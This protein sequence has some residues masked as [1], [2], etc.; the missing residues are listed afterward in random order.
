MFIFWL[1]T[2]FPLFSLTVTTCQSFNIA[3]M[4]NSLTA[5][6]LSNFDIGQGSTF[7]A[8]LSILLTVDHGF[9]FKVIPNFEIIIKILN[10]FLEF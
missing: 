6:N 5:T 4:P 2:S 9:N 3:F 1:L 7:I 8:I 10:K